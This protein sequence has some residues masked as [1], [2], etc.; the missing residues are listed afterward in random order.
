MNNNMSEDEK[1][2][3]ALEFFAQEQ[4]RLQNGRV[5]IAHNARIQTSLARSE[6]QHRMMTTLAQNG[7][8][9]GKLKETFDE[10]VERGKNDMIQLNMGYFYAGM[11]I[12]Y[13]E[14]VTTASTDVILDFLRA[15][16]VR[17]GS[18]EET[19]EDIIAKAE[20]VVDLDLKA[21]D[22]PPRPVSKGSRKDRA[23]IER[24]KKTGI[25]KADLEYEAEIG[26]QHGR[27]SEFFHSACYAVV[28]LVLKEE[29]GW[30][31]DRIERYID[32]VNDLRYEEITRKDILERAMRETGI[33]VEGIV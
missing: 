8:T 32:R 26:Y 4:A 21:Y 12:A 7:I 11:A 30:D 15:V 23:A 31:R 17:M 24:V 3:I 1:R 10:A 6:K 22:T 2:R 16:A 28:V 19:T 33:D 14:A 13:K 5:F 20:A 27:N 18:E 9:W 25:T 29:Y